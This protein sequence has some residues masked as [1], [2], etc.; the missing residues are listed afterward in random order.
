MRRSKLFTKTQREISKEAVSV[1]HQLLVRGGFIDQLQS[2]VYTLLPLGLK[3]HRK[4]EGIVRRK[5]EKV[6]GQEILMPAL[7]PAENWKKTGR[8]ESLDDLVRFTTFYTKNDVALGGTHEEVVSPL[9]KKFIV[10]YKDLPQYIFQIQDKFRDEKRAKSGI[11]RGREFMMKDLYSF[12]AD[13]NDLDEYYEKMKTAYLEIFDEVGIGEKTYL[14]FASGGTFSKYSHE[15]Q[16]VSSAGEDIIY[17]CDKCNVA[18]NKEIIKE[19]NTCPECGGKDFREEKSI[20]TGNIFKLMTKYSEPFGLKYSD[21][22]GSNKLVI[23]G[24]YGIGIGRLMGA[25]VEV[26]HDERGIIWP[27]DISPYD[28]YLIS[29]DD[30]DKEAEKLYDELKAKGYK[31]MFD[32]RDVSGPEKLKDADLLGFP[33]RIVVSSKTLKNRQA[34]IKERSKKDFELVGINTVASKLKGML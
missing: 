19:Q 22:D 14:T 32:D 3:V 1:N 25:V 24:C 29:M 16:T 12:H 13:E 18:I 34:E 30:K 2:G 5:M 8:W 21:K 10:S 31:V 9:A 27:K 4:I 7:H 17:I 33:L 23:M 15:F 6:Q 28:I 11:L 20:E 26:S